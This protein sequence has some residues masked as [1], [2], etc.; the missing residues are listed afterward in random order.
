MN[1]LSL[2]ILWILICA[3]LV[4]LMQAG[5]LC[6]E[7]GA[8]RS[9][10]AIN[11]AMKNAV[12]LVVSVFIFWLLGF[13][14]MFGQSF[15]GII[16]FSHFMLPFGPDGHW[17]AAF[18]LFQA[19]FCA[20]AA[21]IV[22]GAVAERVRFNAYIIIT[23]LIVS[24]IY[25]VAGHWTW[26]GAYTEHHGWLAEL[27]F[28]DFAGST[29]VHSVGGWVALA[30]LFVIGPRRGRFASGKAQ[31]IPASNLPM[32]MLG[33]ILFQVGWIGFNGGSTLELN[34]AVPGIIA[35]TV[36]AAV[37]G[38]IMSY[39]VCLKFP[40]FCIDATLIPM[41]GVLAGMV[42]ITANCHAVSSAEAVVIGAVGGLVMV[43][44][45]KY[46]LDKKID[47]AIGAVPVHL[48]AGIWGTLALGIFGD[49]TLIDTGLD[50]PM[51]IMVQ[52]LG[53]VV[54]GVWT[55]IIAYFTLRTINRIYPLRVSEEEERVG[56][57][58][59]EHGAKTE[60]IDLLGAMEKQEKSRDLS[61]RVPVE[62]FTEVGQIASFYNR[63]IDSLDI[64][65]EQTKNIVRDIRDGIITFGPEGI[66]TSFNPGAEK[67]FGMQ[68]HQ[69]VG[70]KVCTLIHPDDQAFCRMKEMNGKLPFENI[71]LN[72]KRE[73]IAKRPDDSMFDME[74]T[75]TESNY[76]GEIQYTGLIRDVSERKK[77]EDQLYQEKELA[78]VTLES[79]AEGVITTN[80]YGLI[81]Y[82]NHTAEKLTGWNN[83][84]AF[85]QPLSKVFHLQD[86]I[87]GLD[88]PDITQRIL[89]NSDVIV[90][91]VPHLL[92]CNDSTEY[93]V[94]HT[95]API[96]N[97]QGNIVGVVVVF[98][99]VSHAR[100]M[101][102]QLSYQATHD[103]LTG[104]MNRSA[105]ESR[106]VEVINIARHEDSNH[107]L[108]YMDLDQFKLVNDT[109]GHVAGDELLRQLSLILISQ[110]RR[111][112]IIA[113]LGGD[114]FGVL[115]YGCP[116]EKGIEIAEGI[117]EV[118]HNF[119][120]P[121]DDRQ[122]AVGVSIGIVNISKNSDD[123]TQ[124]LSIADAA[125]FAA[126]DKGRNRVHVYEQ[127]DMEVAEQRGQ[128]QW[129]SRIRE[130]LD[131]DRFRLYFQTITPVNKSSS[132][133]RHY[134]IFVRMLDDENNI[135][136]P[137][138]FIPSA[139]RFG[140]MQEID[141]WVVKN[142]L[143]WLGDHCRK[144]PDQ[145][146][147][148]AVN[149]SGQSLG[150]E[151]CLSAIKQYLKDYGVPPEQVCFEITETAAVTN[152][153][154]ATKFIKDLKS[155]GCEFALDD[156]GSGLSS[157]GY[158]KN[159]PVD[160]LKIDGAFIKDLDT[161]S[162]D[163]AMVESINSIG[164]V[165]GLKT[166]AEFVENEAILEKLEQMGVDYAQGYHISHPRPLEQMDGVIFMPR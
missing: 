143:A 28:V 96:L 154:T 137:G 42:S 73:L 40:R 136:P 9:K 79:I 162:V 153:N 132:P 36:L 14:L 113:R 19:M 23:I 140:L 148:C 99:D 6:L 62:P 20:T 77:I 125:C 47:D 39:L 101:Q 45:D 133:K 151:R 165:M 88:M 26:G 10:N 55:F 104:L 86:E 111:G 24:V 44:A 17:L 127:D 98:H 163:Y 41:N 94:E 66:L 105:F 25:P 35:N 102:K 123:L 119:R 74:I 150:D 67:I 82:L 7:S 158:L 107:V 141:Q 116:I 2:D 126:K 43:L 31:S 63:V 124:L 59:S 68:A 16:G 69:A 93:S 83:E 49:L 76:N 4:L 120:F 53:I 130:A 161:N 3:V 115:L 21:T 90:E 52:L 159:L 95:A 146:E 118:I 30:A 145:V 71:E 103:S 46:L 135:I 12:D 138:A 134:E 5:F 166:I 78:L 64:A 51:Q 131:K 97:R 122:F 34:N 38:G 114:E 89:Q 91:S 32:A 81:K 1:A 37:S 112:D 108:C 18:F 54:Y 157:F 61:I 144:N 142:T 85:N 100:E 57:N 149:L 60:L 50:R 156:F 106:V 72:C 139:E 70:S 11:V 109:C 75:I 92:V 80:E 160:Y 22:S 87:T 58:V 29:V 8:T 117:R 152:L 110:M 129:V 121:W 33:I 27:G 15:E 13:A 128:M 48:A 84:D 164:H 155:L 56:L 147:T 65:I